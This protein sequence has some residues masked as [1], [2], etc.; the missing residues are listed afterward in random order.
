MELTTLL[1]PIICANHARSFEA[2]RDSVVA[3]CETLATGKQAFKDDVA[4][5]IRAV[6]INNRAALNYQLEDHPGN[7]PFAKFCAQ[8]AFV[9]HSVLFIRGTVSFKQAFSFGSDIN[10]Q[11]DHAAFL[12]F[13]LGDLDTSPF[14]GVN[15][16][17]QLTKSMR[18]MF[19][20]ITYKPNKPGPTN[21]AIP[22]EIANPPEYTSEPESP[23][24]LN[25]MTDPEDLP[26]Y[27]QFDVSSFGTLERPA[28][29]IVPTSFLPSVFDTVREHIVDTLF[30]DPW[31]N[32]IMHTMKEDLLLW[33][34]DRF[35]PKD[36]EHAL[37]L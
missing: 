32:Y 4:A 24:A 14:G 31:R 37:M 26:R 18:D 28:D 12:W 35:I 22:W 15:V 29:F 36:G 30:K 33:P 8:K 1:M 6:I 10:E 19:R 20:G 25:D 2:A 21:N 11:F 17:W 9:Y 5:R 13:V 7:T 16:P 3:A 34:H 27:A 23:L